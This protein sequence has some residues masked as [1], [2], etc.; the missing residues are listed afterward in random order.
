MWVPPSKLQ[1]LLHCVTKQYVFI[2]LMLTWPAVAQ[3]LR[4]TPGSL[5]LVVAGVIGS[6][7]HGLLLG[8]VSECPHVVAAG[9]LV[10]E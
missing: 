3:G 4:Q 10:P 8:Y 7:P 5:A 2:V 6:P 1:V 9:W